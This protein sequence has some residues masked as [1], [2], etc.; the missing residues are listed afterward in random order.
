MRKAGENATAVVRNAADS[1]QTL[2][3]EVYPFVLIHLDP[4]HHSLSVLLVLLYLIAEA[5]IR[6]C[7]VSLKFSLVTLK[8]A[9]D[10]APSSP[11]I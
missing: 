6:R 1:L 11:L 9:T 5:L 3:L 10:S 8:P 4:P 7:L 2:T